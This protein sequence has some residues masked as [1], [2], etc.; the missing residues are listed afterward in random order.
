M[1][2][3]CIVGN[4]QEVVIVEDVAL[5][6]G[7]TTPNLHTSTMPKCAHCAHKRTIHEH[8]KP[9]ILVGNDQEVTIVEDDAP[10]GGATTPNLQVNKTP[11]CVDPYFVFCIHFGSFDTTIVYLSKNTKS[12]CIHAKGQY[13]TI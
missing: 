1:T 13:V 6:S 2:F 12:W 10:H 3:F 9:S 11:K 7:A 4:N 8:L 5:P